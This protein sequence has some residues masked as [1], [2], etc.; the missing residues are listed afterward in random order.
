MNN[1]MLDN[2]MENHDRFLELLFEQRQI[3]KE[4]EKEQFLRECNKKIVELWKRDI[5]KSY[6]R[7]LGS[8]PRKEQCKSKKGYINY[9]N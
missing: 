4:E 7:C 8:K 9:W 6:I 1:K 2:I 5:N 3:T